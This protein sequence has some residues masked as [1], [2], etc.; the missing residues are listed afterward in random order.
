ME[1]E[2]CR[3]FGLNA[4]ALGPRETPARPEETRPLAG[5]RR[6]VRQPRMEALLSGS[7]NPPRFLPWCLWTSPRPCVCVCWG[8]EEAGRQQGGRGRRQTSERV[9][10]PVWR[11]RPSE[12]AGLQA[13]ERGGEGV[14][15][16]LKFFTRLLGFKVCASLHSRIRLPRCPGNY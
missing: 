11:E 14:S 1:D 12:G 13:G 5:G 16:H 6:S 2:L 3:G 8:G 10:L 15:P 4:L 7:S 9:Q